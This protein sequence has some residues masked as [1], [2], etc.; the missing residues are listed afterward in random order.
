MCML[1]AGISCGRGIEQHRPTCLIKERLEAKKQI[2]SP[3]SSWKMRVFFF[4]SVYRHRGS[5]QTKGRLAMF[6][7]AGIHCLMNNCI[8]QSVSYP[9]EC[10]FC[11]ALLCF[12]QA[13]LEFCCRGLWGL[14]Q[15]K[16]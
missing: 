12:R 2:I 8:E 6:Q 7:N 5:F 14:W 10:L 13:R 1:L 11:F 16:S 15:C 9:K 4:V 3:L